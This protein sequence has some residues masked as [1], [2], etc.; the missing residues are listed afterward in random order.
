MAVRFSFVL[1]SVLWQ[2]W[3][4]IRKSICPL[5][6]EWW[7]VGLV[8]CLER[9]ADCFCIWSSWCHCIPKPHYLLLHLKPDWLTF[10]VPVYRGCPG[11]EAGKWVL[12]LQFS[13][14]LDIM[15]S[16]LYLVIRCFKSLIT[17]WTVQKIFF[18]T[19]VVLCS[20][21]N[22]VVFQITPLN[23]AEWLVVLKISFPVILLDE[24]LKFG[25]RRQSSDSSAFLGIVWVVGMWAAYVA[26][27]LYSPW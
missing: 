9:G 12:L 10:L 18:T 1:P 13:C 4:G 15:M 25:A 6:I 24:T 5:K 20:C 3:L 27:L 22:Q 14:H 23:V 7:G 8:I 11:K 19:T 26:F 16:T 2:C 21:E 17:L